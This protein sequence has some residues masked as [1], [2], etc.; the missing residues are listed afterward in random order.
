M[1]V[2]LCVS[3]DCPAGLFTV[4]SLIPRLLEV[5]NV[6]IHTAFPLSPSFSFCLYPSLYPSYHPAHEVKQGKECRKGEM[7]TR[8]MPL[9]SA[10][11]ATCLKL[12]I[13]VAGY[14]LQRAFSHS[15]HRLLSNKTVNCCCC[16]WCT[17]RSSRGIFFSRVNFLC[18]LLFRYLY[19]A[20][21]TAVTLKRSPVIQ[22]KVQ[23]TEYS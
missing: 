11:A 6:S 23:V 15:K 4:V 7:Q 21:V 20:R 12:Y 2:C 5:C 8:R 17:Q 22:P 16:W 18:W 9:H 1:G 14:W 10:Q 13:T 3:E 19:H